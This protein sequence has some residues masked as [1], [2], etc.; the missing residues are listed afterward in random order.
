MSGEIL[1]RT[2]RTTIKRAAS[3]QPDIAISMAVWLFSLTGKPIHVLKT[4]RPAAAS[5]KSGLLSE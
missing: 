3:I 5:V 4:I 2:R 1:N